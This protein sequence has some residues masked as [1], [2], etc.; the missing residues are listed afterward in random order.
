M[1][2]TAE[3]I[4]DLIEAF[5]EIAEEILNRASIEAL[6]GMMGAVIHNA[7]CPDESIAEDMKAAYVSVMIGRHMN[8]VA[9]SHFDA[10]DMPERITA[11]LEMQAPRTLH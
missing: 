8:T 11:L 7:V 3:D 6:L 9:I 5:E 2:D 1:D 10:T 4:A